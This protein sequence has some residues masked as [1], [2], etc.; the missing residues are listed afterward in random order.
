MPESIERVHKHLRFVVR[1]LGAVKVLQ[2]SSKLDQLNECF[3]KWTQARECLLVLEDYKQ[4]NFI[5]LNG[6]GKDERPSQGLCVEWI[7]ELEHGMDE[8]RVERLSRDHDER[9]LGVVG[10]IMDGLAR[11]LQVCLR[12]LLC[13][14]GCILL[15]KLLLC[16]CVSRVV[17]R[18]CMCCGLCMCMC[19][20]L[21][22]I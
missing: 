21:R 15:E 13:G 8:N 19:V 6:V 10:A 11:Q 16:V 12:A 18:G 2:T 9:A 20:C 22:R 3:A 14:C 5:Q 4:F 17:R 1:L 7:R